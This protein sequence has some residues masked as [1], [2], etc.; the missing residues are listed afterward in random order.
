MLNLKSKDFNVEALAFCWI[1]DEFKTSNKYGASGIYVLV[2][3]LIS[4]KALIQW[5]RSGKKRAVGTRQ[6][7]PIIIWV[8]G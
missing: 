1:S 2:F 4:N 6:I 7:V 5:K 3:S 8:I